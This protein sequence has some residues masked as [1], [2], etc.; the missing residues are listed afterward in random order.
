MFDQAHINGL[1]GQ[2]LERVNAT[3]LRGKIKFQW[4]RRFTRRLGDARWDFHKGTGKVRFSIPLWPRAT[5][6][7]RDE[8]VVHEV[9]HIV[10]DWRYGNP[11]VDPKTGKTRGKRQIHNKNWKATMRQAGIQNPQRCHTVNRDGLRRTQRKRTPQRKVRFKCGCPEGVAAGAIVAK[12]ILLQGRTYY[13]KKC[14]Q[15]LTT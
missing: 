15:R 2:T 14:R 1:I 3:E 8:V 12:R 11:Y 4:S 13:C 10:A 5:Q 7:Q 6:E 9:C